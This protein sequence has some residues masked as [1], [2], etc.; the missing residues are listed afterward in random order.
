MLVAGGME[1]GGK[2]IG[3]E[4]NRAWIKGKGKARGEGKSTWGEGRGH[5]ERE[6][7]HR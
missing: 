7:G 5:G 1:R 3:S 2:R 4:Q 6:R